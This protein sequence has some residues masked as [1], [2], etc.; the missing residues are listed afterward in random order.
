MGPRGGSSKVKPGVLFPFKIRI[1]ILPPAKA[2]TPSFRG[3]DSA[4]EPGTYE[5]KPSCFGRRAA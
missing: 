1:A 5:Y 4:R 2:E 3:A